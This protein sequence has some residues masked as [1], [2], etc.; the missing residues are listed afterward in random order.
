M[1][2]NCPLI[3]FF[4]CF[5]K[6]LSCWL[7]MYLTVLFEFF[8]IES[9]SFNRNWS[10]FTWIF[11]LFA[12]THAASIPLLRCWFSVGIDQCC[13]YSTEIFS[14]WFSEI[15]VHTTYLGLIVFTPT[16]S[17]S[18]FC[19]LCSPWVH[20]NFEKTELRF[21]FYFWSVSMN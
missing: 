15:Y 2:E 7:L 1:F 20:A 6:K 4:K 8:L 9:S 11:F 14:S 5:F 18:W 17:P 21:L 13:F 19:F 10:N 3:L 16:F 12:N